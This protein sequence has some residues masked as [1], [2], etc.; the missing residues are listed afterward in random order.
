MLGAWKMRSKAKATATATAPLLP[1]P[2][3][4]GITAADIERL[5]AELDEDF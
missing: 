5:R 2:A 4:A 3:R 1:E